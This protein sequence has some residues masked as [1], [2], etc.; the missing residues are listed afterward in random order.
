MNIRLHPTQPA[1]DEE[2]DVEYNIVVKRVRHAQTPITHFYADENNSF[3]EIVIVSETD[4]YVSIYKKISI[5]NETELIETDF[6]KTCSILRYIF[7]A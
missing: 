3:D 4:D 6:P 7:L 5:D 1:N 2:P